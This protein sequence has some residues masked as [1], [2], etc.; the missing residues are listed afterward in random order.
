MSSTTILFIGVAHGRLDVR[1]SRGFL[2]EFLMTSQDDLVFFF[3][4][5]WYDDTV[6]TLAYDP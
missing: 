2:L 6:V 3:F 5:S 4:S 1:I